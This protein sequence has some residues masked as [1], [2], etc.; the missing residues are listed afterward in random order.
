D[1][2]NHPW[3]RVIRLI[4][5]GSRV[6]DIGCSSGNMGNLLITEKGCEVVGLDLDAKDVALARKQLTAAY[7]KN[8]ERDD[9][10]SLGKFDCITFVDVIEHLL[11]PVAALE[12]VRALLKPN[13]AVIFSIPNMAHM[14]VRLMLL[15]GRFEYAETGLLDKT[16]LHYYDRQEVERVFA[17]AG[18]TFT[19]FGWA[20]RPLAESL[21][22]KQLRHMGLIADQ[23][24]LDRRRE[25]EGAAYE[26]VGKAVASTKPAQRAARP[27]AS[28]PVLT[29]PEKVEALQQEIRT[30]EEENVLLYQKNTKLATKNED[31][32]AER[33]LLLASTSWRLTKP[34]RVAGAGARKIRQKQRQV[35]MSV[36]KNPRLHFLSYP[37]LN[38]AKRVYAHNDELIGA[39]KRTDGV[40]MAVV[41]HLYY[42]E[43]WPVLSRKL[44]SLQ[45]E[46]PFDLFI[47]LPP[48]NSGFAAD[49]HKD[50]PGAHTFVMSNRG[51]D[52]LPF[53]QV[54]AQLPGL[55]YEYVLKLHSKKSPHYKD[56]AKW[57]AEILDNLVPDD[58]Q[59]LSAVIDT[60]KQKKTGVIGPS[61]QYITLAVNFASNSFLL[62][63]TL[64]KLFSKDA[65]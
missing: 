19:D 26:W 53:I 11:D 24:F 43:A 61:G 62:F 4:P 50:F 37:E 20:A 42:I 33:G 21:L 60:L 10:T 36:R 65:A 18:F 23:A 17:D 3:Y 35:T 6:L 55:G 13:G 15:D 64:T 5:E 1:E 44:H 28:P 48:A 16:H 57:F 51:R 22:K 12:K 32:L 8:V 63:K 59:A 34:V 2:P 47:T 40:T 31:L 30:R 27:F 7:V 49:V 41:I 46:A 54:A 25:V 9:L 14:A 56:G 45:T 38:R 52:V 58:R 29:E 39:V